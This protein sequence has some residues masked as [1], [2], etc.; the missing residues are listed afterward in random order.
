MVSRE[1]VFSFFPMVEHIPKPSAFSTVEGVM[2]PKMLALREFALEEL[3]AL[4]E[5]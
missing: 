5:K 3:E 2:F 4:R 1:S